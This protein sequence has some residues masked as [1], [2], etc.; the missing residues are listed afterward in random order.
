MRGFKYFV[1]Y[2]CSIK[3]F[4]ERCVSLMKGSVRSTLSITLSMSFE[5]TSLI[6]IF[7]SLFFKSS[8]YFFFRKISIIISLELISVSNSL[9]DTKF[10]FV[11]LLRALKPIYS[12]INAFRAFKYCPCLQV[13]LW[14]GHSL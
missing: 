7:M 1:W 11:F 9:V 12:I 4:S 14:E 8:V 13:S 5:T 10:N 3:W 2:K 6:A